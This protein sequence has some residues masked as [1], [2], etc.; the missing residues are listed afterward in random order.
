MNRYRVSWRPIWML[1]AT[2]TGL[3][4]CA[5]GPDF[6]H[7]DAPKTDRYT[8]GAL[9][10]STAA[11][12]VAG[13]E[14]QTFAPGKE[15]P[16]RW[17]T[18]FGSEKLN[19]RVD[20]AFAGSPG[21]AAAQASLRQAAET[22][23]SERSGLFPAIDANA[24]AQRQKFSSASMGGTGSS[25]F[26]LYNASVNVSYGIDVFGG[27]RRAVEA[28][29]AMVDYQRYE[30][31]ATYLTL[32]ANVVTSSVQEASLRAQVAATQDIVTALEDQL[33]VVE[34]QHELGAVS[35]ADVLSARS[36][37][38]AERATLSPLQK[39]LAQT[40]HQLA[41]YLGRLPSDDPAATL[42]LADLKLPQ[43][44]PMS[45]PSELVR[46]RPDVQ[47]SEAQL[48][49]ASANVG[50]ATAAMFPKISI[51]GSFG[52]DANKTGDLFSSNIWN[53]GANIA[54]PLF[55]AGELTAKRRAAIAA[56]DEANA[57]YRQ[58]VLHSFQDVADALRAL[59]SDA[60]ALQAQYAAADAAEQS[61]HLTEKQ[62]AAGAVSHLNLLTAQKQYQQ[63]RIGYLQVLASRY[64]DTAALFQALG[65]GI[66]AGTHTATTAATVDA[67]Q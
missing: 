23:N 4:A 14:T 43:E 55:H 30:L 47:A 45:V 58:T 62:Y 1:L 15:L 20:S 17:W 54:Q 13:G 19:Q 61:L 28:Q 18:L 57:N 8:A 7:P 16:T 6:R 44:L 9:P 46:R 64:T 5:V 49:Q 35:L 32:A 53:L 65:G 41:V 36:N 29:N 42:E 3:S 2:M 10:G 51:T 48:H 12:P 39:Q 59:E 50:L 24:S 66:D 25:I 33:R 60:Q 27:L 40:Q 52:T 11:T 67:A 63:V 22:L 26:N 31:Q 37:L 34:K 56:Y 21:V 38:A